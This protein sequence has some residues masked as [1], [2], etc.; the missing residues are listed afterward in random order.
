MKNR[1][2]L[3]FLFSLFLAAAGCYR[4]TPAEPMVGIQ[5]QDRNGMTETLS[6][7][8][9]LEL[10][11]NVDFLSSQPYKKVLRVYKKE[12][13]NQAKIT[14]YHPNGS[15]WQYLEAQE[16]RAQ[17]A[18]REWY[19]NGQLRIEANV[20]GG[21]ADVSQGSQQDWLFDGL[22]RVWDEQGN[23]MAKIPYFKGNLDGLSIYYYSSGQIA[24]EVPYFK[25]SI[26]GE[27][28]EFTIDGKLK[29]NTKYKKG[30]KEG[31]SLG[32]FPNGQAAW[33]EEHTDGLLL[34]GSYFTSKGDLCAEVENG[35]GFQAVF[36]GESLVYLV[37][38]RNG[39]PEGRVQK[40][41]PSGELLLSYRVKGGK[42]QG[43][44]IEYYT[45]ADRKD[46]GNQPL[47]KLSVNWNENAIHG[48]VKTWYNNGQLQSQRDFCRNQKLGPSVSWYQ[49][50]SLMMVEEY[51]EDLLVKGQYFKK[52]QR[53][54]VSSIVN[55]TGTAYL[56][57]DQGIFLRKVN[58]LKGKPIDPEN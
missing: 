44:E 6:T 36:D 27:V 40:Y 33:I 4:S 25:N 5:I 52:N 37:E 39:Q 7:P 54:P 43:E 35:G 45:A 48:T 20:I 51:E 57:D 41:L 15:V 31:A 14:T 49:D 18:Y 56:F 46:G 9:R 26:E 10:Y 38:F 55:G 32:Y 24:K 53:D 3:Y 30:N 47:P 29:S 13:K 19:P 17:G 42:K 50:G 16:M 11:E 34:T 58:Y 8:E 2:S 21:T 1:A 12:G 28:L 22:S 23:L